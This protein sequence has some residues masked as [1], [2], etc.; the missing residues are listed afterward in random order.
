MNQKQQQHPQQPL[1]LRPWVRPTIYSLLLL[2]AFVLGTRLPEFPGGELGKAV[3][4]VGDKL[5]DPANEWSG[6]AIVLNDDISVP[7]HNPTA[8]STTT[9]RR[10]IVR[11]V[12]IV[13]LAIVF[14]LMRRRRGRATA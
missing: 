2:G 13:V 7:L 1:K 10:A 9:S 14:V 4:W 3:D 12:W 5:Y 11:W 8:T 6:E